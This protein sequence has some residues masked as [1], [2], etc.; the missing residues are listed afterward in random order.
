M[1][2]F[3]TRGGAGGDER[4]WRA[5]WFAIQ[6]KKTVMEVQR[7][8]VRAATDI[9]FTP[10]TEEFVKRLCLFQEIHL[11]MEEDLSA[12]MLF[13]SLSRVKF[14]TLEVESLVIMPLYL[15]LDGEELNLNFVNNYNFWILKVV[16]I[17]VVSHSF[18]EL[19]VMG[20]REEDDELTTFSVGQIVSCRM[21]KKATVL[22]LVIGSPVWRSLHH[23]FKKP[24]E[25][26]KVAAS[27]VETSSASLSSSTEVIRR[28]DHP[29]PLLATSTEVCLG[30]IE[31]AVQEFL[32]SATSS[33]PSSLQR[34][35]AP[36][37]KRSFEAT[38]SSSL[39]SSSSFSE[40]SRAPFS[41][42]AA[43][44]RNPYS[45]FG[46]ISPPSFPTR[47]DPIMGLNGTSLDHHSGTY[48]G[49]GGG[50]QFVNSYEL[51][52]YM[53]EDSLTHGKTFKD[54]DNKKRGSG[55][56]KLSA[57][58]MAYSLGLVRL[59]DPLRLQ[60]FLRS[61]KF[62]LVDWLT[63]MTTESDKSHMV[64]S[65]FRSTV[66]F[67]R[68][69]HFPVHQNKTL[70]ALFLKG[71]WSPNDWS[72][73]LS[74]GSFVSVKETPLALGR[75]ASRDG[76][77]KLSLALKGLELMCVVH[78]D[79]MFKGMSSSVCEALED[80]NCFGQ[81]HH[82]I[83]IRYRL[84]TAVSEFFKEIFTHETSTSFPGLFMRNPNEC[85][86]L[87]SE[88]MLEL[89]V[90]LPSKEKQPHYH[91]YSTEGTAQCI[92]VDRDTSTMLGSRLFPFLSPM[93]MSSKGGSS[94]T[95]NLPLDEASS[96]MKRASITKPCLWHLAHQLR[97]N[98]PGK[99]EVVKCTRPSCPSD[100]H[101]LI[102]RVELKDALESIKDCN[103]STK[104][105]TAFTKLFDDNN[106]KFKC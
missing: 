28:G 1:S 36:S 16:K 34:R 47:S 5:L 51:P 46:I 65:P 74:L 64:T 73:G 31:E 69:F 52:A 83:F 89:T 57:D 90:N 41:G 60:A 84:E 13:H 25:L 4:E 61:Y 40:A 55:H 101:Q 68:T 17:E 86:D 8:R 15:P 58:D 104:L 27:P 100:S 37:N 99:K 20:L 10:L 76:R 77:Q 11:K 103:W 23:L 33:Q 32:P 70:L 44:S 6:E 66:G 105:K 62:S 39:P 81:D 22:T 102:N 79:P 9:T 82:D 50:D 29:S 49:G 45:G 56:L 7:K 63:T 48:S 24:R 59:L 14:N 71:V 88:Y 67:S 3:L 97:Y 85:M 75:L 12:I 54:L 95:Q 94:N 80:D 78:F 21:P 2:G 26:E 92:R 72:Q 96:S 35:D 87:F 53:L 18:A 91:W 93:Q 30:G 106:N 98:F 38:S 19:M 42:V 43:A